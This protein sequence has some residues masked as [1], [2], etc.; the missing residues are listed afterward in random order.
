MMLI[1]ENSKRIVLVLT[2]SINFINFQISVLTS[3]GCQ[4]KVCN[5]DDD[6]NLL[7]LF[8]LKLS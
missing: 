1:A 5:T 6:E 2:R 4:Q 8:Q 7:N 3:A